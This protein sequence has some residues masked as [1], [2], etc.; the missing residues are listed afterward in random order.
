[1]HNSRF[2]YYVIN[3][4]KGTVIMRKE[5]DF[6][7]FNLAPYDILIQILKSELFKSSFVMTEAQ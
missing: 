3:Y 6:F 7:V 4:L 5:R 2:E 1:M